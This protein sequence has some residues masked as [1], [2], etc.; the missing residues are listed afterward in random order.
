MNTLQLKLDVNELYKLNDFIYK[1]TNVKDIQIDLIVEENFINIVNYSN[2]DF[3]KVN[4]EFE[5]SILMIEFIDNG[6]P[7]NPL[8]NEEIDLPE[9]IDEAKVGGLGIHLTKEI[10]DNINYKYIDKENHLRIIKKVE[11]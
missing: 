10:A 6:I 4:V 1:I 5:N 9:N 3:I 11:S 8:L 7:F 2:S